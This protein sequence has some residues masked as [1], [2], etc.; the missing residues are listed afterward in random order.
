MKRRDEL[1]AEDITLF[2]SKTNLFFKS[3]IGKLLKT[4]PIKNTVLRDLQV[5]H[6]LARHDAG[7]GSDAVRRLGAS[8][9]IFPQENIDQATDEL[10]VY[11]FDDKVDEIKFVEYYEEGEDPNVA[12]ASRE[13]TQIDKFWA[14]VIQIKS[15]SGD[16]KYPNLG[17]LM[18]I[19][20]TL[21]HGQ[22]AI[23]RSFSE[24]KL[25]LTDMRV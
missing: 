14:K 20:L 18:K 24:N 5:I 9:K 13:V 12:S 2:Y 16:R 25:V 15:L 8:I 7:N 1:T 23:E 11:C 6:P 22:A 10:K 3:A 17:L 19:C 21:S 4:L